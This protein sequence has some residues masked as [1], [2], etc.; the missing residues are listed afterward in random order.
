MDKL[1]KA[2]E[3]L[4]LDLVANLKKLSYDQLEEFVEKRE[5]LITQMQSMEQVF[6]E[7]DRMLIQSILRYDTE[8]ASR[9]NCLKEEAGLGMG[10]IDR[11]RVQKV[12]YDVEYTPDS[13]FFDKR[14]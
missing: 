11:A 9:M 10:K 8:I 5:Q 6:S 1:L 4:T 12:A 2:L 3:N 13:V 7:T 14:K